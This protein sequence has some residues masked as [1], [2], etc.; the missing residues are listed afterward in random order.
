M[1]HGLVVKRF[2]DFSSLKKEWDRLLEEDKEAT[3]FQSW[4]WL[5]A[6]D[7]YY[8]KG[9]V[10]ILG[11][12]EGAQLKGIGVFERIRDKITFL[13]GERTDY[14]DILTIDK[15]KAWQGFL[16]F[17]LKNDFN[18]F[19]F[20]HLREFSSS[21]KILENLSEKSKLSFDFE[22]SGM[23]PFLKLPA[24][25]EQ[26][27]KSLSHH[28]RKEI[29]RKI[30]KLAEFR[31]EKFCFKKD[32]Y[33]KMQV[34]F[35]LYRKSSPEKIMDQKKEAFYLQVA[36]NMAS[37]GWP[38]LCFLY[39]KKKPIATYFSFVFKNKFYLYNAGFDRKY[40]ALA[41]GQVLLAFII[42]EQIKLGREIFDFLQGDER[43]KYDFGVQDQGLFRVELG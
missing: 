17:F 35:E 37:A 11:A 16:D 36:E 14:Q 4:Q 25:W 10:F 7:K 27:L 3:P 40:G 42:K 18:N 31:T 41:P 23:A 12:Y 20:H 5:E 32:F 2:R 21:L 1:N 22:E 34:F 30:K 13:G 9:E 43:F 26:Y 8:R 19:S 28:K 29:K 33:Q 24:S 39:F 38:E 6:Y 15:E